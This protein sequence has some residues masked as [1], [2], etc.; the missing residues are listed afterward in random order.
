MFSTHAPLLSTLGPVELVLTGTAVVASYVSDKKRTSKTACKSSATE[1]TARP[2]LAA[3]AHR[4]HDWLLEQCLEHGGSFQLRLPGQPDLLVTAMPEHY[5]DVVKTH[6]DRFQKG[7]HQYDL[8]VDLM[9]HSVLISEGDAWKAQRGLLVRLFRPR[10]LRDHM[11]P[12]IQR[13][14]LLLQKSRTDS[15]I[16]KQPVDPVWLWKCKRWLNVG[17]ERRLRADPA[18]INKFI[19]TIILSALAKRQQEQHRAPAPHDMVSLVL[20]CIEHVGAAL[21]PLDVRNMAVAALGAGRDTSADSMSWFLHTLTQHPRVEATLR[22]EV[23]AHVPELATDPTYVPSID[24]VQ[25]LVYL[26]ALR[27]CIHD[28]VLSDGT[29]V[30]RGTNVGL[31]HYGA[32]RRTQTWGPDAADF[33]PEHFI[34]ATTGT[35]RPP[36]SAHSNAFSGGPSVCVGKTLELLEMKIAIATVV[37]RFH[38]VPHVPREKVQYGMGITIGMQTPLMMHVGGWVDIICPFLGVKFVL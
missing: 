20:D 23:L 27:E 25:G 9:G 13:L 18:L 33:R 7:Q 35:V 5:V 3:N 31:C 4:L 2:R 6:F 10:A 22:A 37:G 24:R 14:A 30:P 21:S 11:L 26:D 16:A 36:P 32:A 29:F 17:Q 34:D 38:C 8:F 28:T 1:N 19:L 12:V 15:E